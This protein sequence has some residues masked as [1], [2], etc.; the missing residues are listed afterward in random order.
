[1]TIVD[2]LVAFQA[3]ATAGSLVEPLVSVPAGLATRPAT[4]TA[5]GLFQVNDRC[6]TGVASV[7]LIAVNSL[8]P[9]WQQDPR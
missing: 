2:P 3:A 4:A 6:C 5:T 9:G 8:L 7:V 1:V